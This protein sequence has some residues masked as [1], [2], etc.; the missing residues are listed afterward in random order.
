MCVCVCVCVC[1]CKRY[2]LSVSVYFLCDVLT[3]VGLADLDLTSSDVKVLAMATKGSTALTAAFF[4]GQL[5]MF[6]GCSE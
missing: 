6:Y 2:C 3:H 5:R 4:C 1:P